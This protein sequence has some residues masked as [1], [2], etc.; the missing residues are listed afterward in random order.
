MVYYVYHYMKNMEFSGLFDFIVNSAKENLIV[1][2]EYFV[3][4]KF[5]DKLYVDCKMI[6]SIIMP[7]CDL[8]KYE[9]LKI[10]YELSQ[11]LIDNKNLVVEIGGYA[12]QQYENDD[13]WFIDC[14]YLYENRD[15]SQKSVE[16]GNCY[17]YLYNINPCYLKDMDVHTDADIKGFTNK[18]NNMYGYSN[19]YFEERLTEYKNRIVDYNIKFIEEKINNITSSTSYED[20]KNIGNLLEL[21]KMDKMNSDIILLIYA[22]LIS[23]EGRKIYD[24][25]IS[26]LLSQH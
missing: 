25:Y 22:N 14:A 12:R 6:G 13:K 4:I 20:I 3:F 16:K 19:L 8:E 23:P 1:N 17:P 18:F 11:L 15:T 7:F 26:V 10:F 21:Y 5:E 24:P 2:L 9:S